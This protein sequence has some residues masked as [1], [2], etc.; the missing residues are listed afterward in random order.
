M[1]IESMMS[2]NQLILCHPLLLPSVFP[3]NSLLQLVGSLHQ[4]AKL[5]EIQLQHQS[6]QR[7]FRVN[8]F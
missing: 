6:L 3:S 2:F 1:F 7:I 4:V 8:F 5:L